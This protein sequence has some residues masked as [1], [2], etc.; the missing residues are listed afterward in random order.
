[1][2]SVGKNIERIQQ[3]ASSDINRLVNDDLYLNSYIPG[4]W[5]V[6]LQEHLLDLARK[7]I[8]I[9]NKVDITGNVDKD[10]ERVITRGQRV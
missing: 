1:M 4:V 7:T 2:E 3:Y 5:S 6:D 9:P 8:H 10:V